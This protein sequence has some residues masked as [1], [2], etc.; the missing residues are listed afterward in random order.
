MTLQQFVEKYNGQ[1][2]TN[3]HGNFKG[4][5]VSL[6][7]RYAQESQ[8]VPNADA[9]LYCQTTGGARDLYEN[10]TALTLKYYMRIPYG[11]PRLRGDLVVWGSSLGKY[12]DVAVSLAG[13]QIFGQLGTPVFIPANIRN[14]ARQPLGYLRL[15]GDSMVEAKDYNVSAQTFKNMTGR[16]LTQKEFNDQIG[17]KW[18]DMLVTFQGSPEATIWYA[19]AE[20]GGNFKPV[21]EQLY[22][23][24]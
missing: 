19:R 23:K 10:P 15:K 21:T 16:K 22:K 8:A 20:A 24:G 12:G 11:Q 9:V 14:E 13:T 4:E 2:L 6:A 7:C 17:R 18:Q 3:N 1:S 5:C